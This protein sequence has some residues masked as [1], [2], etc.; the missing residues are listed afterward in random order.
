MYYYY[1]YYYYYY[2][3]WVSLGLRPGVDLRAIP[4][5]RPRR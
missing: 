1:Y 3:P 2:K 4:E 5:D